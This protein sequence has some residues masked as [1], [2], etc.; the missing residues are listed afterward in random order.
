GAVEGTDA[1]VH[2][3]GESIASGR[4][5]RARK[6]RILDSR[7][8]GTRHVANAIREAKVKPK[9]FLCAS[10]VGIYGVDSVGLK[11]EDGAH[12]DDF[13]AYVCK[14]WEREA[15]QLAEARVVRMRFGV[16]LSAAGGAL[17]QMLPPFKMGVGGRLG[18]GQQWMSWIALDDVLAAI[19]HVLMTDSVEGAVNFVAP[20]PVTNA[21]FTNVLGKVLKRPTVLPLPAPVVRLLLGEMGDAL[22]LGGQQVEP[23]VLQGSGFQYRYPELE[24][25]L[26]HQLGISG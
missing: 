5:T 19:H 2:L 1:V 20:N 22:L 10:A 9:S 12:G 13:L 6:G 24:G 18:S 25:A 8:D 3:A 21:D 14:Q 26:R 17:K 15:L 7:V 11:A 23:R 4:W 16:I